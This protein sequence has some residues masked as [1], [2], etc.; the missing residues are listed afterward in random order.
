[1]RKK[2]LVFISVL[3]LMGCT[4]LFAWGV[5]PQL[6]WAV[7]GSVGAACTFKFDKVPA[8]LTADMS[9]E[10][11]SFVTGAALDFWFCNPDIMDFWSAYFGAGAALDFSFGNTI[12][13][14]AGP[15]IVLGT[16][17]KFYDDYLELFLQGVWQ[18]SYR[19]DFSDTNKNG[20]NWLCFPISVGI[21]F[22]T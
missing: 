8:V 13:M 15:R 17:W 6:G 16:N 18:P 10:N 2:I 14:V 1:M 7:N 4:K 20:F 9:Y 5:G 19:F 3:V 11:Q 12:G 21:R 22:H